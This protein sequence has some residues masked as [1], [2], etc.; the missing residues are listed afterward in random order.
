MPKIKVFLW[1]L[2]HNALPVRG[3]LLKRVVHIDPICPLCLDD[4]ESTEHLFKDCLVASKVWDAAHTHMWLPVSV[5]PYG[6]DSLIQCSDRIH[7]SQNPVLK[8]KLSF[9]LW[10]L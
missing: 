4:I 7:Q 3:T 9:L 6:C 5:S 8:H 10:S 1:Q 2:C